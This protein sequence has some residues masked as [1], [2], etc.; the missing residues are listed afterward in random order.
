MILKINSEKEIKVNVGEILLL[1]KMFNIYTNIDEK[2]LNFEENNEDLFFL[3]SKLKEVYI[4]KEIITSITFRNPLTNSDI[5]FAVQ[6]DNREIKLAKKLY[7]K[8]YNLFS[9]EER[10]LFEI[11][12]F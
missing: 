3:L 11:G 7:N 8:I 2:N 4:N 1:R 6:F 5:N 10:L 12:E 9:S